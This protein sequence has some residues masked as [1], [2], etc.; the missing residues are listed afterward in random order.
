[1]NETW[2]K[3]YLDSMNENIN[4]RFDLIHDSLD[5]HSKDDSKTFGEHS[6]RI[7]KLEL[8]S[9]QANLLAKIGLGIISILAALGVPAAASYIK[10]KV[11]Q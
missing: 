7:G 1:M 3:D 8:I 10:S 6:E 4:R 11:G 2:L 9:T 5:S